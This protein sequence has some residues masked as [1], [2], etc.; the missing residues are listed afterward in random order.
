MILYGI[1]RNFKSNV[2][3][4]KQLPTVVKMDHEHPTKVN[5]EVY[6][7]DIP[8]LDSE[9]GEAKDGKNL[10]DPQLNSQV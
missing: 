6:P 5:S 2:I 9:N 10:E 1:Y 3:I 8:S 7:F 4:E